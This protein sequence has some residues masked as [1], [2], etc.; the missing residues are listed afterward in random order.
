MKTRIA[1]ASFNAALASII[2][3]A[4]SANGGPGTSTTTLI[5]ATPL[6]A[7]VSLS[8]SPHTLNVGDTA[9]A[10]WSTQ[11]ASAC[12]STGAWTGSMALSNNA[13]Q[14]LGPFSQAGT[15]TFGANCTGP[16]GSG[17][18]S[19]TIT[20][21]TVPAPGIQFQLSPAAIKPGDSATLTWSS[22]NTTSCTGTGGTGSDGWAATQPGSNVSGFNTGAITTPGTY[23]YNLSCD[24]AGG[25]SQES[26]VLS[27][28]ASA[29]AAPPTV[30]INAQ[31]AFL[32][33]GQ[34]TTL[35]WSTS[36]ATSCT[37]SGGT[38]S[39]GWSGS[40]PVSSNATSMGP[41]NTVGSYS[42]T[43][44]CTGA[45]GTASK[46][47]AVVVSNNPLPPPVTVSIDVAPLQ[48]VAGES[49][50]LSWTSTN[51]DTCLATGSWSGAQ[52]LMGSA[53]S[54]GTLTTP[55]NYSFTLACSGSGGTASAT[56]VASLTVKPAASAIALFSAI[57]SAILTGQS[58]V[59]SWVTTDA[60]SCTA[61]GGSGADAWTGT[62]PASSLAT[63]IGPLNTPGNYVYTLTCTGPGGTSA[64]RTANV[65]VSSSPAAPLITAFTALQ[66][67]LLIGQSTTLVWSSIGAS[68]CTA[69]GGTG[70]DGWSG[71]Q[72]TTGVG[73]V[74][75]PAISSGPVVY[76]LI[77][78]GPGGT[79]APATVTV[80][81]SALPIAP[82]VLTF[83]AIPST[84]Q[85]GQS[86]ILS[87]TS[88]GATSC[89]ASGGTG[90]DGWGGT[91]GIASAATV[92][93]PL[94][95]VGT[96]T[97]TLTCTGPGGS[98]TPSS[99]NVTVNAALPGQPTVTLTANNTNPA[100]IQP[101]QSVTLKWSSTNATSCTA[102]GG[103]LGDGWAGSR[104]TSSTGVTVGPITT[105]GIYAYALTCSGPGGSGSSIVALTVIAS[106]SADCGVGS[107][108]T[109][110][111]APAASASSAVQGLC[112]VGCGVTNLG[113][114]TDAVP[115]NYATM[116]VAVG[117]A[118]TV[119]VKVKDNTTTYPAGRNVGFL[120][121]DPNSLLSLSLLQNVHVTTLLQGSVQETAGIDNLLQIK[122]LGLL[123]DPNAGF[124]E[125]QTTKPFDSVRVDAGSLVSALSR[126]RVYGACVSL[127]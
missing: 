64:P 125:F 40:R 1:A 47:I 112:L 67:N 92:V 28:D 39:D 46:S 94:T 30:S 9:V 102:S 14:T 32:P 22:T 59:L 65:S 72:P 113:N 105:P 15:Y 58:V 27:V 4:C 79:T 118:A 115:T 69:S 7:A 52:Q 53:V 57:P 23:T 63:S 26:R 45:G 74:V 93:G 91:V 110:L 61:S 37:A 88:A 43:L 31:P 70:S 76:T 10:T 96:V 50:N 83:L 104:P 73:L 56:A 121:A 108:T 55:G 123:N 16:G 124:V 51:A 42:Y 2:L 114:V 41:L 17:V 6:A 24:G 71:T 12:T 106:L 101:G 20:V 86:T 85:A 35:S 38:G 127:Q 122:A 8:V 21:G 60:T 97:Y 99:A 116:S 19:Q 126:F 98:S 3:S 66:A 78:T 111:V 44:S 87:W 109:Y 117:V 5:A 18:A 62:V 25:S 82:S 49:A 33:P 103:A 13:G 95:S 36:N 119:S 77:C 75:G 48:I 120:L 89:T 54:T 68:T 34:S 90:T 80:N 107:P 81:V 11:N 84:V 29:P 100:Q